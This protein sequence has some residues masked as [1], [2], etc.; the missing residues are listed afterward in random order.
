MTPE[1]T[2]LE[3]TLPRRRAFGRGAFLVS[4]ANL[5]ALTLVESGDWPGGQ[6][7][8]IGPAGAGKTHLGHVWMELSGAEKIAATDLATGDAP[9]LVRLGAIILEDADKGVDEAA[10]F[11]L[12]N[13]AR[14]EGARLLLTGATG[15]SSWRI[16]TP[17][18]RSRLSALTVA[19]IEPPDEALLRSLLL[20]HFA[21]RHLIVGERSV[22]FIM[23]HVERS[24]E[25]VAEIAERLDR[26]ALKA[27]RGITIPFV[28]QVTGW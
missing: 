26:E 14:A 3:V 27:A 5:T 11:H 23:R 1:Q 19:R 13:L 4:E 22:N 2:V 17:D 9:D 21:D 15:P 20:K 28:K 10:L 24:A 6:L 8:L 7:A 12:M 25:G 16:D 18:L